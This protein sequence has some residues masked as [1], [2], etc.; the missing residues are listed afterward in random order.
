MSRSVLRF[1]LGLGAS[2]TLLVVLFKVLQVSPGEVWDQVMEASPMGL[3]LVVGIHLGALVAKVARW[4]VLLV[5]SGLGTEA[6]TGTDARL[7]QDAVFCGWLGNL[8]LPAKSGEL[9]RPL[10]YS[11]RTGAPFAKV[12]A[13]VVLERAVDLVVLALGFWVGISLLGTQAQLP[14]PFELAARI[15]G[16]GGAGLVATLWVLWRSGPPDDAATSKGTLVTLVGRFRTGLAALRDPV[17]MA[18]AVGWTTLSWTL[19]VVGA[20]LCLN[21]FSVQLDAAWSASTAHVVTTTLAVSALPVPGGLGIE[22]PVSVAIFQPFSAVPLLPEAVLAV[23]LVLTLASIAW[24][25]P[26]GLLGLWRQGAR[27]G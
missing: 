1:A 19:E 9:V 21:A 18:Q 22:Q 14:E 12:F 3:A 8:V 15:A 23:S 13:T 7:I 10:L 24:V 27:L 17:A 16:I 6:R 26:L 11:R 4:K 20:W 25:V 5:A 2:L